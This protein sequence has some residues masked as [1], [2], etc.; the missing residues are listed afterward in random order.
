[1]NESTSIS[2]NK[3]QID[4]QKLRQGF[5]SD[6]ISNGG[7][8]EGDDD[9]VKLLNATNTQTPKQIITPNGYKAGFIYPIKGVEITDVDR[10]SSTT[11]F[12]ENGVLETLGNDVPMITF[13]NGAWAIGGFEER[14]N[15][16][17]Y[18]D[19][20]TQA[21]WA[22]TS[23]G[24]G[25]DPVIT[26]N[27]A[28]SI[29]SGQMADLVVFDRG[30]GNTTGDSSTLQIN[31]SH[32]AGNE[33]T[34]SMYIKAASAVD[35][36]KEIAMRPFATQYSVFTLTADWQKV[37]GTLTASVNNN[38]LQ[39]VNR[40]GT[41]VDNTV[42]LLLA[43]VQNTQSSSS[44]DYPLIPT[45]GAIATR[46]EDVNTVTVPAGTTQITEYFTDGTTNVITTIPTTHTYSKGLIRKIIFE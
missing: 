11:R 30:V 6:V 35:V 38:V 13:V 16:V 14:T 9:L 33:Y 17:T 1:M 25:I 23:N 26:A 44:G 46:I 3:A 42:S 24:T 22:K 39:I 12:D 45:S 18:S 40:G 41:T 31:I 37:E 36:G 15:L 10:L 34:G 32:V 21:D 7:V 19:D 28:P 27:S 4:Y 20:F 2:I 5:Y 29:I 8:V 43:G